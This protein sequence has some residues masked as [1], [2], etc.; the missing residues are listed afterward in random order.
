M[1]AGEVV[2]LSG[3]PGKIALVVGGRPVGRSSLHERIAE[4]L[5]EMIVERRLAPGEAISEA[6]F[7]G[8]LGVSR[9]PLREALK[10]LAA[11]DLVELRP[12]RSPRVSPMVPAEIVSLFEAVAGIERICV[13]LAA[14][15]IEEAD[16]ARLTALQT[17]L[18]GLHSQG[19]LAAYFRVNQQIHGTLVAA[20]RNEVLVGTHRRLLARATRARFFALSSRTR[21]DDSVEEHRAV[22]DALAAG[23]AEEAGR[24]MG[25]HVGRTGNVVVETLRRQVAGTSAAPSQAAATGA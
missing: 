14:A 16:L 7:C 8:T 9:T 23:Q 13:E 24:L 15:R 2:N 6:A 1:T 17:R 25:H 20:S 22:L 3:R 10:L 18:E 4:R 19:D 21:W 5:R 11:E 12:N